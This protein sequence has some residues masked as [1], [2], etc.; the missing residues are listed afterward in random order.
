MGFNSGQVCELAGDAR[1]P[2]PSAG[3]GREQPCPELSHEV[4][5]DR[6]NRSRPIF[7]PGHVVVDASAPALGF[8]QHPTH[9]S[10]GCLEGMVMVRLERFRASGSVKP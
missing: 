8:L 7:V 2:L 1:L 4:F 10:A 3:V 6:S 9:L 5:D